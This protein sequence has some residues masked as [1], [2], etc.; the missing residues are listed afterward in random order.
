DTMKVNP[1]QDSLYQKMADFGRERP[2]IRLLGITCL[3]LAMIAFTNL[4]GFLPLD[5]NPSIIQLSLSASAFILLAFTGYF[6]LS[7]GIRPIWGA[8]FLIYSVSFL[9]LC[10]SVAGFGFTDINDPLVFQFWLLPVVF[11]ISG[12]WIGTN[13]LFTEN[14]RLIYLP[15]ILVLVLGESWFLFGLIVLRNVEMT[16]FGFSYGLFIPLLASFAYTWYRFGKDSNTVSPW[17]LALGFLSMGLTHALWNPWLYEF[18]GQL[19]S[20]L[21]TLYIV[22]LVLILGGFLNLT[23]DLTTIETS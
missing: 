7:N 21:F 18:L 9:G 11:F 15:A 5:L 17:F 16:A 12:M 22:S 13:S 3:L 1:Y 14:K 4:A 8:S 23:R 19:Y 6:L 10:L 20:A 2:L